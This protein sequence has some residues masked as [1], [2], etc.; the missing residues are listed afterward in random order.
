M[1]WNKNLCRQ[2]LD[3]YRRRSFERTSLLLDVVLNRGG[4]EDLYL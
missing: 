3:F 2:C 4:G 1:S